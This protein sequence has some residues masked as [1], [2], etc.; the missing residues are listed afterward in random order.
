M[1]IFRPFLCSKIYYSFMCYFFCSFPIFWNITILLPNFS[2][3]NRC[4]SIYCCWQL[5][6]PNFSKSVPNG[7]WCWRGHPGSLNQENSTVWKE[8]PGPA[9][10]LPIFAACLRYEGS[11]SNW[12]FTPIP[13]CMYWI[14]RKGVIYSGGVTQQNEPLQWYWNHR[15][16][17]NDHRFSW[18]IMVVGWDWK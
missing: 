12:M 18:L 3:T 2:Q 14:K 10:A 16:G 6:S 4:C 17:R 11:N 1:L 5:L 7:G 8:T 15:W 13:A 9:R